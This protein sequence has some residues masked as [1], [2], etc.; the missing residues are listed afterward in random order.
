MG[1]GK[2]GG[3]V[4]GLLKLVGVC[5]LLGLLISWLLVD[6]EERNTGAAVSNVPL[7]GLATP[8]QPV[9]QSNTGAAVSNVPQ[10]LE[11]KMELVDSFTEKQKVSAEELKG[12][13]LS[14]KTEIYAFDGE[15]TEAEIRQ[16]CESK[17]QQNTSF[18]WYACVVFDKKENAKRSTT[19]VTALY[20]NQ[21]DCLRHIRV[22][23]TTNTANQFSEVVWHPENIF[24]H[25][26][27]NIRL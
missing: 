19:P 14:N 25:A 15:L 26:M 7:G 1:S 5:F 9:A 6:H 13:S 23:F 8:A 24:E 20:G 3:C 18:L 16:F 21:D 17:R 4:S 11:T 22:M 2:R 12:R 10:M 27:K